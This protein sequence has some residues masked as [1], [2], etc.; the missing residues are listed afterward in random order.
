M[1][2]ST[3]NSTHR[4]RWVA[5]LS[6]GE[7]IMEGKGNFTEI[8]GRLSPWRRLDQYMMIKKVKMTSLSIHMD[9]R[10]Y[11]LPSL[12]TENG[13]EQI[14]S[15]NHYRRIIGDISE[16]GDT[17]LRKQYIGIEAVYKKYK[18]QILVDESGKNKSA[19]TN[20]IKR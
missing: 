13:G 7:T 20:L 6:N 5:G 19:W 8:K 14:L 18:L 9:G 15:Y 4:A 17:K 16:S 3:L 11:N 1:A 12:N 2:T 10:I